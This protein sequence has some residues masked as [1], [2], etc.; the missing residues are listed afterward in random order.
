MRNT[1]RQDCDEAL[2]SN[3]KAK[4]LIKPATCWVRPVPAIPPTNP[5]QGTTNA[6][7]SIIESD[8]ITNTEPGSHHAKR[9]AKRD[10]QSTNQSAQHKTHSRLWTRS[11]RHSAVRPVIWCFLVSI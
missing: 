2:P 9:H 4:L 5:L 1:M 3:G 10:T 7:Q 11:E 6:G 8:K